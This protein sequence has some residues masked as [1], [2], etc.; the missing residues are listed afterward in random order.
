MEKKIRKEQRESTKS[1]QNPNH[2]VMYLEELK[3]ISF[4]G[5]HLYG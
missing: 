2:E 1:L 4:T 3:P 5:M